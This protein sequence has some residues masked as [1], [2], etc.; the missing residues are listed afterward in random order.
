[1]D[2]E[3]KALIEHFKF[4]PLPVEGTLFV[5]TYRSPESLPNGKPY[6]TGMIGMYCHEPRSVSCF[7][8]LAIDEMWHFYGGDPLR[9][10]LL[11]P[12]GSSRDVILGNDPL[13]GQHVQFVIPAG[14]WQ[15][16]HCVEGGRYSLFGC[17]LAPGFTDDIFA[18]GTQEELLKSYPSR[19]KDILEYG[20]SGGDTSM[21]LGFAS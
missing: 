19:E 9:L 20:I 3:V 11:C 4:R 6:G 13:K 1:M 8:K 7:H 5:G 18:G 14:V 16:G 17:T 15:A 10:I 12:D 2:S 21:P